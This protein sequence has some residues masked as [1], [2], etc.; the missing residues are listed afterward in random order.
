MLYQRL[1]TGVKDLTRV[2]D[3]VRRLGRCL[4]SGPKERPTLGLGSS[5]IPSTS[6]HSYT[7]T[8]KLI[9]SLLILSSKS[10]T[11]KLVGQ[12]ER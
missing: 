6:V 4:P 2:R 10:E 8:L 9:G 5:L 11:Q 3:T 12:L 1:P 7:A